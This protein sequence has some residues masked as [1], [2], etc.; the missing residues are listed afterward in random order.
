MKHFLFYFTFLISPVA[1][2][3]SKQLYFMGAGGEPKGSETIFDEN[4]KSVGKFTKSPGWDTTLSVN[5]GHS[6]TES[7]IR[8]EFSGSK[9][10]GSFDQANYERILSDMKTKLQNGTLK[11]GDK[12]MVVF[13]THG[14]KKRDDQKSHSIAFAGA[15]AKNLENLEG[16]KM[17]SLDTLEEVVKLAE[18]KGVKLAIV[19]LSC[20]SGNT[21]KLASSK[22]CVISSTGTDHPGYTGGYTN[23]FFK[24]VKTDFPGNFTDGLKSGRNLEEIF[25]EAREKSQAADY[26]MIS[27]EAG[28]Y[29]SEYLYTLML[30]FLKHEKKYNGFTRNYGR[31]QAEFDQLSCQI[32]DDYTD[33][34]KFL[35]DI[36]QVQANV[37]DTKPLRAALTNYRNYQ[38][39]YEQMKKGIFDVGSEVKKILNQNYS[40]EA[41]LFKHEEGIAILKA[42]YNAAIASV[43]KDLE[44]YRNNPP[45]YL[46]ADVVAI[47]IQRKVDEI[48]M[49]ERKRA[50]QSDLKRR[51]GSTYEALNSKLNQKF[52]DEALEKTYDMAE[53]VRKE[54]KKLYGELYRQK[55]SPANN[56]CKDFTL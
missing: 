34:M 23:Y 51:V 48:K 3:E 46:K 56:P 54:T 53:S 36:D 47:Q 11:S 7:I 43:Q 27:T 44:M 5:G 2:A 26:P 37:I 55:S 24:K 16:A 30:P 49:I 38:L 10:L 1:L 9:N 40:N 32:R 29:T 35:G 18:E 13:E 42:D 15:E 28:K 41:E 52:S 22:T 14:A 39:E 4:I 21:Q 45:N 17:G 19:D 12:L 31:S 25:L 6:K 50:I 20:Y 8:G 33:L